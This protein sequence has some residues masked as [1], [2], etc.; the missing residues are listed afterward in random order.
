MHNGY[1]G[2]RTL[3]E[4]IGAVVESNGMLKFDPAFLDDVRE[5]EME[6]NDVSGTPV[7]RF[8]GAALVVVMDR[9][10][11]LDP[12]MVESIADYLA[13]MWLLS[14]TKGAQAQMR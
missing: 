12:G 1:A 3:L 7:E 14:V 8:T 6:L 4:N 2:A 5:A 13:A 9:A 10:P 11:Y